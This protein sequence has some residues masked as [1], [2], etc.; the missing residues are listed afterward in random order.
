MAP[1]MAAHDGSELILQVIHLRKAYDR[2]EVLRG[3]TL[4]FLAGAKIGVIGPNGSGKSTLLRILA[5]ADGEFEG[6]RIVAEGRSIGYVPQEPPLCPED[7]VKDVLDQAVAH[8][9]ATVD[10]YNEVC[11]LLGTAEGEEAD[12]LATEL[13]R[14]QTMIDA[15]DWWEVD[16]LLEVAAEALHLP[17]LEQRCGV[18]SGGEK[19]RVA[20]CRTL[21]EQPDILL[22]DEPTNHL[23]AQTVEWLEHHLANYPGTVVLVTHD[24]Y[25][26]DKVVGWMLEMDRGQATP[27]EGN[28]SAYLAEKGR[29]MQLAER[30]DH[31]RKKRL[32][33]E[34]EW[35]R[36]N[37]KARMR[38]NKARVKRYGRLVEEQAHLRPE[39]I[40]LVIPSGPHLGNKVCVVD[41][42]AKGYGER[43]LFR[44]LSF[45]VPP[46]AVVGVIGANGTGKTTLMKIISGQE[47]PDAG[48]VELGP[49]V[50]LCYVDQSRET[51]DDEKTVF[52]EISGGR[53]WLPFGGGEIQSRAYVSRFNFKGTIQEQKVGQL[54]GGQRNRVLLAKMLRVGGNFILLDE[55]TNDL[56]LVTLRV[57]EEAI[58]HYAGSMMVVSH[59]RYFLDRV[60][61]H[62]LAFE[63]D[64]VVRF[65]PGPYSEYAEWLAEERA[66]AGKGPES[67]A[68]KYRKLSL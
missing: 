19:R 61:T 26:L 22:L 4:G 31:R 9:H 5:G 39:T 55:P 27:Y 57:L 45:E 21:I 50:Q 30:A 66:A 43:V 38:K 15:H 24:R 6:Q 40:D 2:V 37:P 59:D 58:D 49:T 65:F 10:R 23:D 64:G 33:S 62:T 41:R 7:T 48:A 44:D 63:G 53:E 16:R 28:Y 56:D 1:F 29:K 52:E 32:H 47:E 35:L 12:R 17:P 54:S 25:F 8:A 11:G 13:D 14:L 3:I 34:L 20:L 67:R 60:S 68:G 51:L 42:V 18:L 36:Q 46:G